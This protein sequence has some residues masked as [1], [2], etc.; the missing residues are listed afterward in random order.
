MSGREQAGWQI[1]WIGVDGVAEQEQ[2][3]DR[4]GDEDAQG[5]GVAADLG[6]FLAHQREQARERKARSSR[7]GLYDSEHVNERILQ[8]GFDLDP[9]E[10]VAD[11]MDGAGQI[12]AVGSATC[13]ARP[14]TA[15]A[16]TP[17]ACR[18]ARAAASMPAPVASNVTSPAWRV[19]SS[20]LPCTT[21]CPS[22]R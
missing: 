20:A 15:A 12:R 10:A 9:I 7:S 11:G 3:H 2:L 16:S 6:P 18:K 8:P 19:T 13:S 22:A 21:I 4:D 14:N 5:H 17:L 1:F